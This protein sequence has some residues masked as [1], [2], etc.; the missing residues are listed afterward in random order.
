[1]AK[2]T[3]SS[4][5]D[6]YDG[7]ELVALAQLDMSE[8]RFDEALWKLKLAVSESKPEPKA[9]ALIGKLYAQL[10]MYDKAKKHYQTYLKAMPDS[11]V[12]HFQLGMVHFDSGDSK[13]AQ[14][15]WNEV[16][17]KSPTFPPAL[18]YIAVAHTQEGEESDARK[19]IDVLI[20]SAPEDNYYKNL[21]KE[22][23][24]RINGSANQ[25]NLSQNNDLANDAY[26]LNWSCTAIN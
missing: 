21:G 1:M 19:S 15:I 6:L 26:K 2:K 4:I 7:D 9:L 8:K 14:S 13:T 23:L 16:L 12:E 10:G 3:A 17:K 24:Q 5:I 20:N 22:L 18:Y 25:A 11:T